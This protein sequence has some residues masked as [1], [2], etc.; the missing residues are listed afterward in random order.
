VYHQRLLT[1]V[2]LYSRQTPTTTSPATML[3][4][5][6]V[7][8]VKPRADL[9]RE[10]RSYDQ[11]MQLFKEQ[12][13]L[14]RR[15]LTPASLEPVRKKMQTTKKIAGKKGEAEPQQSQHL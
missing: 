7:V 12:A 1:P 4:S 3:S 5:P 14:H 13:H 6:K 11:R 10:R 15:S 8:P 9:E 2:R